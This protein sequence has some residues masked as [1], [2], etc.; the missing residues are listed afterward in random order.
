MK[1]AIYLL[2]SALAIASPGDVRAEAAMCGRADDAGYCTDKVVHH[3][4]RRA[5]PVARLKLNT[6][7]GDAVVLQLPKHAKLSSPPVV[8]NGAIYHY[9]LQQGTPERIL[10]WARAPAGA[11]DVSEADL[12]G[13]RSNLQLE[14]GDVSLIIDLQIARPEV[15][16]QRLV[17][18]FP[19]LEAEHGQ[20]EAFRGRIRAEVLA[21]LDGQRR[22]IDALARKLG[23]RMVARDLMTRLKCVDLAE[24]AMADLLVA[25]AHRLC[26]IGERTYVWLEVHNRR[27]DTFELGHIELLAGEGE[28]AIDAL[29]EWRE[30]HHAETV[31]L[32]FDEAAHGIAVFPTPPEASTYALR[33]K[34]HGGRQRRVTVDDIGF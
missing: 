10:L 4:L 16:T 26:S 23:T 24:R 1:R 15:S 31:Q 32:T 11:R 2:A 7:L 33:I 8:G 17:V 22:D 5:V 28:A 14:L 6:A 12:L 29:F 34:E 13:E 9:E 30:A 20:A 27:R 25:R 19:E 21:E 3:I 18:H